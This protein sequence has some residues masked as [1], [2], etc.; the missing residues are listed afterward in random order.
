MFLNTFSY[1]SWQEA[2]TRT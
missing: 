1:F 2:T